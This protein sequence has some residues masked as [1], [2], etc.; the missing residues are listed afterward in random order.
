LRHACA[1][2]FLPKGTEK[3]QAAACLVPS[4][5]KEA[6][7]GGSIATS[8][9]WLTICFSSKVNLFPGTETVDELTKMCEAVAAMNQF[10]GELDGK[11]SV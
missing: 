5:K 6:A 4:Y 11:D 1:W 10:A 3:E 8:A 7:R 9:P 2:C